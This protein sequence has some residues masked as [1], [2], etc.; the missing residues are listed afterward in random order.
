MWYQNREL[1][2]G[3][4]N[5]VKRYFLATRPMFLLASIFP[6][7]VGTSIAYQGYSSV[8]FYAVILALLSIIFVHAGVNV[9]NDVHDEIN[10]TDTINEDRISP[11]TGGSRFIQDGIFSVNQMRQW[12][13]MLF[14]MS[15][16][17]GSALVI[18]KGI[19]ILWFGLAG[20]LLGIVYSAPPIKLA[21]R[22]LGESAVA[23]GF[24]LLP[25]MGA[26]WLQTT[27]FTLHSLLVAL[28]VSLWVTNILL[29]NEVP[30]RVADQV[31]EKR[32]L[33]VRFGTDTIAALY[34]VNSFI[35]F[36]FLVLAVIWN[37]LDAYVLTMSA[38]LL[39]PAIYASSTIK[40]W[41]V[42]PGK[43]EAGIKLTLSIHAVNCL[44]LF[45][46]HLLA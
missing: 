35:A 30:D 34:L 10:G 33:A 15:V 22:G 29:I 6:V 11:Y 26:A 20:V 8:D 28:S 42:E 27:E 7:L 5:S 24:G 32:T 40:N 38:V 2:E 39:I 13:V 46:C 43:L 45:V 23:I 3:G 25:V 37:Y 44:W 18:Y 21:S 14:G 36:L 41:Q 1:V 31:A 9:F 4:A 17:F 19:V 16:V 12:A